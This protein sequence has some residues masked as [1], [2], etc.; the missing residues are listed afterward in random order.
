MAMLW[1]SLFLKKNTIINDSACAKIDEVNFLSFI[2]FS[3]IFSYLWNAYRGRVNPAQTWSCSIFDSSNVNVTRLENLWNDE[4]KAN[5]TSP[6]LFKVVMRFIKGRLIMA[7]FIFL[8]CLVFGFIGPTCMIRGLIA[9]TEN[10]KVQENGQIDYTYGFYL[11]IAILLVEIS[12]VLMYGAT[13]AV[14]YRTGIRVRGAILALLYKNLAN[15]KSLRS[16][17]PAEIVNIYANDGQRIFDAVT[18]A[19]LVLVGPFVLV[20]GLIYLLRG[21]LFVMCLSLRQKICLSKCCMKG[22]GF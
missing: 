13:W 21:N 16:K 7:C 3:W 9:F 10:P 22:Y 1:K 6:S 11:V 19:P 17:T 2:S 20:G 4:L 18:F 8:F 5:P 15:V 14:S 12:R